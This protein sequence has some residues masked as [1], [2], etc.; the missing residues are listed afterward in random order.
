MLCN[1]V[2]QLNTSI[3]FEGVKLHFYTFDKKIASL[4]RLGCF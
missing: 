3:F 2:L 4:P 1:L